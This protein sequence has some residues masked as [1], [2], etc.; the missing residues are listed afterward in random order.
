M[1]GLGTCDVDG[2]GRISVRGR[3]GWASG[4]S[5]VD[6]GP[7]E[8]A[9]RDGVDADDDDAE[10]RHSGRFGRFVMRDSEEVVRPDHGQL[11]LARGLYKPVLEAPQELSVGGYLV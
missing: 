4:R 1:Y 5:L 10:C 6:G 8:P 3:A 9:D 2:D 11:L 7:L